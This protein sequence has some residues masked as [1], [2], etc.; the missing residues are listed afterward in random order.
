MER[1]T[2]VVNN[3]EK[4]AR[5]IR[6]DVL[7]MLTEAESGHTGGS[8][9]A[10][11]IITALYFNKMKH[12]PKN[13]G[14]PERDIFVLSKGHAAPAL[15]A[16]LSKS[17]YFPCS[18]LKSLRKLGSL[19][20]GH[21]CSFI[22]PGV[23]VT[24][25]SLGQGLS[26]ANGIALAAKLDKQPKKVYVLLGD[27]EVQEGQ[28]WEAAMSAAHYKLDNI[29]AIIDKNGLQ[30]DGPT[31]EVMNVEPLLKKWQAFGWEARETDG[32][33]LG[34]ILKALNK[35]DRVKDKPFVIIAH[36]IKGKGVSFMENKVKY[37]GVAP[38]R[39][40]LERALKE[41]HH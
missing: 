7:Q 29:C 32:H 35:A 28:V 4:I 20:Q 38:T 14:S 18:E 21:P 22:T 27:G 5:E 39:E 15:Y 33:D 30:I 6:I 24:T 9:S 40:E 16:A 36:T 37:H 3:L 8:L 25:G 26:L 11:E 2:S 1:K 17:G 12:D 23:D 34:E 31:S 41:I 13:P 19:L 10:I